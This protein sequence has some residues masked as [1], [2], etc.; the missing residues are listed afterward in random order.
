M[1]SSPKHLFLVLAS[2][3]PACST[4]LH[5]EKPLPAR[6]TYGQTP[7]LGEYQVHVGD[8]LLVEYSRKWEPVREY[9]LGIGDRIQIKAHNIPGDD[10]LDLDTFVAPDGTIR[11]HIVGQVYLQGQSLA[12]ADELITARLKKSI[13]GAEVD[14]FLTEADYRTEQFI[15]LLLQSPT[16]STRELT[17][18]QNG[19]ISVPGVGAIDVVGRTLEELENDINSRLKSQ[20]LESLAV[21]LNTTFVATSTF[22]VIGEVQK[23]GTYPMHGQVSLVEALAT[24]G[25]E[26]PIADMERVVVL[27][28]DE[29][30]NVVGRLYNVEDSLLHG[31]SMP[32]VRLTPQDTVLV[33][34]S[35]IG[36]A[37][38]FIE[39]YVRNMLPLNLGAGFRL[40][41]N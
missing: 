16:G 6:L 21:S 34:R 8:R 20:S 33:V 27:T 30:G 25:W 19:R 7:S 2:I 9:T 36:N 14:V 41:G 40:N 37:N 15:Q 39:Q 1:K 11:Y 10:N 23:P 38:R 35:G 32:M 28:S 29:D 18:N 3:L 26:T 22:T 4:G 17:V 31:G 12:K 13:P 24:A 5:L